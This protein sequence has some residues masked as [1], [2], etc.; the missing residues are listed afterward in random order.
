MSSIGTIIEPILPISI[1]AFGLFANTGPC[2]KKHGLW[3]VLRSCGIKK[4]ISTLWQHYPFIPELLVIIGLFIFYELARAG[5]KLISGGRE[6]A[7]E[8]AQLVVYFETA[9]NLGGLE[10]TV[11]AYTLAHPWLIEFLNHFYKQTHWTSA[12]F[13]LVFV[14]TFYPKYY[15]FYQRWFVVS[16]L[17]AFVV[18]ILF[19]CAPP[20]LLPNGGWVDTIRKNGDYNIGFVPPLSPSSSLFCCCL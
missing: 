6:V 17:L 9:M 7:I 2:I 10:K 8:N 15:S 5:V 1:F 3:H 11:Q 18:F 12:A 20:R 16:N 14:F 13:F 4:F 19:P